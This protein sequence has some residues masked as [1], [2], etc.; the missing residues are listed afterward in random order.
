MYLVC[1][2][3]FYYKRTTEIMHR[4]IAIVA[5]FIGSQFLIFLPS[6]LLSFSVFR[7][8]PVEITCYLIINISMNTDKLPW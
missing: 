6:H 2:I 1:Y 8:D 5:Q 7:L 4:Q 3:Y